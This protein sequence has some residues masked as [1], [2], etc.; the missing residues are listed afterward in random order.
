MPEIFEPRRLRSGLK[1]RL[2]TKHRF[3]YNERLWICQKLAERRGGGPCSKLS[4]LTIAKRYRLPIEG[5]QYWLRLYR[6]GDLQNASS[7]CIPSAFDVYSMRRI[8]S[9]L[10]KKMPTS[11]LTA[12]FNM[13]ARLTFSRR[14]R[15]SNERFYFKCT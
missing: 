3:S 7:L 9:A 1:Y 11:E 14:A 4:P 13:E 10:F 15:R 12:I 8:S 2:L 5:L 6:S